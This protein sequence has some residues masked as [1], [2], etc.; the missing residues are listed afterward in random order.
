MTI[1]S[2]EDQGNG[3]KQSAIKKTKHRLYNNICCGYFKDL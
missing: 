3:Q 2:K 1:R